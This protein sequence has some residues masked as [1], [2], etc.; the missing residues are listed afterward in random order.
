MK[1][2]YKARNKEGKIETGVIEASSR[3]AAAILLQKYEIFVT[4]LEEQGAAKILL[5]N[6]RFERKVSKKD[7]TIFFRQ[8]AVMLE[9]RVPVVQ[10]LSSL[11]SQTK[12]T[13]FKDVITKISTLVEEGVPLSEALGN[14]PKIFGNFYV[15]L[16]KS[17]EI[18]GNISGALNYI[19]VHLEREDDI[20]SQLK[21][22]M[23]YPA[24]V[25]CVLF[26]VMGVIIVEVVP[27]IADLIKEGGTKPPFFTVLMLNFYAFL[28]HY[29]WAV[30]AVVFFLVVSLVYYGRT[31]EGRNNF[32]RISLKIPFIS[33]LLKKV[34]LARFC[35]NVSTLIVAGISI[36]KALKVT[37]D[38]VNNIVYKEIIGEIEREVS[39]GEKMSST[40]VKYE[41]YFPGFVIQMIKVGEETGK[42]D[43]TL[44]EVVAFYQKEIKRSIDLLSS[45]IEPLM[46][47]FLG[48][49]VALLA[50][51]VLSPLYGAL[52][53]I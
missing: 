6:V 12:K 24:F 9:S 46:I 45:L 21:Q 52:G 26:V 20:N 36:N 42:L 48:G 1:F 4:S 41:D 50:I 51:S 3:E 22:A 19:S 14:Y 43:K 30:L 28:E 49:I 18:S 25:L 7:L 32:N 15:N 33:T 2:S 40:M 31:K 29:W 34:F 13:N 11:A 10:S 39:E 37:G 47:I 16:V 23:V 27:R 53:T 38:T 44:M 35:G 8:L 17:G 5:R